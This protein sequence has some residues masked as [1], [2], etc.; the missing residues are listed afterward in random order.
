[1][2]QVIGES[3]VI[4]LQSGNKGALQKSLERVKGLFHIEAIYVFSADGNLFLA[5][6]NV[7]ISAPRMAGF[8]RVSNLP[9]T[10]YILFEPI[11]SENQT[12]GSIYLR[13]ST[14]HLNNRIEK[15]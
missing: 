8:R 10:P 15:P 4:P 12:L 1:M 6:P 11:V 7:S 9:V 5:Y 14:Q 2:A 3:A 13:V